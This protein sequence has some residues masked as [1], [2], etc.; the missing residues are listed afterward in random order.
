[1]KTKL[2]WIPFVPITLL[3]VFLKYMETTLPAGETFLGLDSLGLI[4]T[5]ILLVPALLLLCMIISLFDR[6]ISPYY[7]LSRN[8]AAAIFAF[9]AAVAVIFSGVTSIM[10]SVSAGNVAVFEF[11]TSVVGIVAGIALLFVA[12][13]HLSGKNCGSSLALFIAFPSVW[14]GLKLVLSFLMYRTVSVLSTDMLD[15]LCYAIITLFFCADAMML[16]NVESKNSVKK[17]FVFGFTLVA[18]VFAYCTKQ[19]AVIFSNFGAYEVSDI[20][21]LVLMLAIGLYALSVLIELTVKARTKDEVILS[22]EEESLQDEQEQTTVREKVDFLDDEQDFTEVEAED[23]ISTSVESQ[24]TVS[25]SEQTMHTETVP[26]D[27]AYEQKTAEKQNSYKENAVINDSD[28][29]VAPKEEEHDELQSRMDEIDK[30]IYEI[31]S[32]QDEYKD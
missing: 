28:F 21:N 8:F 4:Y 31:Q 9:V 7:S 12:S 6:K 17:C 18:A 1:M 5:V 22:G 24:K 20:I 10:D 16:G 2:C 11:I 30:L 13:C 29:V 15:L 32:K 23:F 27:T 26:D 19:F 3:M 14:A 25:V